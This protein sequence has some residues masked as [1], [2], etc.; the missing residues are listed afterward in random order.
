MKMGTSEESS[1]SVCRL[2][3]RSE[4]TE[5][6]TALAGICQPLAEICE[7]VQEGITMPACGPYPAEIE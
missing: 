6:S 2:R 7:V 5:E 3:R 1:G 4:G